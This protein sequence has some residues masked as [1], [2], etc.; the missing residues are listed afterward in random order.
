MLRAPEEPVAQ[1]AEHDEDIDREGVV[2]VG[3]GDGEGGGEWQPDGEIDG[4]AQ[5][6]DVDWGAEASPHAPAAVRDD[7]SRLIAES[8]SQTGV[9]NA[10]DGDDVRGVE[11][12]GGQGGECAEGGGCRGANVEQSEE[13]DDDYGEPKGVRG[14]MVLGIDLRRFQLAT[15]RSKI[16]SAT[17]HDRKPSRESTVSSPRPGDTRD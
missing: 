15:E 14:H 6:K 5:S 2:H 17:T 8:P 9:Q 11:T 1:R 13:H 7:R 16:C 10:A 12:E 3:A 4:P